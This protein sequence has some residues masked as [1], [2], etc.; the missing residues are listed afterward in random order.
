MKVVKFIIKGY[1]IVTTLLW[2]VTGFGWFC[3]RCREKELDDF[4]SM[5]D[6]SGDTFGEGIYEIVAWFKD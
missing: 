6:E 1:L 4:G 3:K 2:A 5:F